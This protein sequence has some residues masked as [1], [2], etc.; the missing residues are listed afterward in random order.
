M[1]FKNKIRGTRASLTDG[2]SI[3]E[4]IS[5][6]HDSPFPVLRPGVIRWRQYYSESLPTM[7]LDILTLI[8]S[9]PVVYHRCISSLLLVKIMTYKVNT[10]EKVVHITSSDC[11]VS[12]SVSWPKLIDCK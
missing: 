1:Y 2:L 7:N 11:L 6:A 3:N 5:P 9:H 8:G 4:V 12:E 10:V